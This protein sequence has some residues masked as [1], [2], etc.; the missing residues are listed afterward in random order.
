MV[1]REGCFLS[2]C[3]VALVANQAFAQSQTGSESFLSH[4]VDYLFNDKFV[5]ID[6]AKPSYVVIVARH[7]FDVAYHVQFATVLMLVPVPDRLARL[8]VCYRS[9][10]GIKVFVD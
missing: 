7:E 9:A 1:A 8:A 6:G 2:S 5:G 10:G 3:M 4:P